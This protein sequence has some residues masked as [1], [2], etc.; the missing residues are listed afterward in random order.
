MILLKQT[1]S[2]ISFLPQNKINTRQHW[3]L[4]SC[5][6]DGQHHFSRLRFRTFSSWLWALHFFI[7]NKKKDTIL[8]VGLVMLK[9]VTKILIINI[10]YLFKLFIQLPSDRTWKKNT[11]KYIHIF[12]PVR[13]NVI[14]SQFLPFGTIMFTFCVLSHFEMYNWLLFTSTWGHQAFKLSIN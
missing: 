8:P 13:F 2:K 5:K 11:I 4:E 7:V 9:S 3:E 1:V 6:T 12:S 14:L 10:N